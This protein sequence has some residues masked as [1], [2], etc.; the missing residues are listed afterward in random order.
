M[1]GVEKV[2]SEAELQYLNERNNA[3]DAIIADLRDV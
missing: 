1:P 2:R 3:I